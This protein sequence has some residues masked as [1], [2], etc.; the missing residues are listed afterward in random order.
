[1][2][3]IRVTAAQLKAKADELTN[4]NSNLKTNVQDLEACEQNFP[5]GFCRC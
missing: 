1:M 4:L 5:S 2:A 3:L